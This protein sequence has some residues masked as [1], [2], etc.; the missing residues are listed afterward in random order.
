VT[1]L[2]VLSL[3][4]AALGRYQRQLRIAESARYEMLCALSHD[5]RSPHSSI[6]ALIETEVLPVSS[7]HLVEVLGSIKRYT[8]RAL[9]MAEGFIQ[10]AR[11]E[12]QK[13]R[14]EP[15]DIG[16]LM[17]DA[18]EE[19]W[20]QATQKDIR[21]SIVLPEAACYA[22]VD[23]DL[24][25]R[26]F[27]NLLNNAVKYSPQQTLI[28]CR[29]DHY[30]DRGKYIR[31]TIRDNGYGIALEH[32]AQLFE[33]FSRFHT[34]GQPYT[35][36]TGLGLAFVRTVIHAHNG[37]ISVESALR[38]GTTFTISLPSLD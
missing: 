32:Q 27:I 10:L 24:M 28:E 34:D 22:C 11:A 31:C 26:V 21:V 6:L 15:A 13:Y 19:I 23:R 8:L 35:E 7:P 29:V 17:T 36:G 14:L 18:S 33:K 16:K 25:T 5:I 20:P 4:M 12:T 2:I 37:E 38:L 9:E 3:V 1:S 30:G